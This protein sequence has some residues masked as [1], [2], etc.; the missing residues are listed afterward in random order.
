M[1]DS[2]IADH[3]AEAIA[4]APIRDVYLVG[5]RGPQD[6]RFS[7][8]ELREMGVLED[9]APVVDRA[10]VDAGPV[11]TTDERERR[12]QEKNLATLREFA[13]RC[14]SEKPKRVHFRFFLSPQEILGETAVEAVR[15]ERTRVDDGRAVGTGVL[16]TI[17]AGLVVAAIGYSAAPL[18][19]VPF[20]AARG[21]VVNEDGRVAPGLYA[22]GWI[23]R[24]PTGVITTLIPDLDLDLANTACCVCGPPVMYRFVLMELLGRG[25]AEGNIW[26]SFERQMKCA[27]GKCGHCQLHH[28]YTCQDG[29]SFSYLEVKDLEEAF[30]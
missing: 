18:P 7:N 6:A 8:V 16:E 17:D 15:F 2:D 14:P 21:A 5:R 27:V 10:D 26:M 11:S 24:G 3:A 20:D 13:A 9:C 4:R 29:P 28:I 12:L 1:T 19:D 22:V 23:K 30:A 25:I